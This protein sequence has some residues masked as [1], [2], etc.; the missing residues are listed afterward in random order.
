MTISSVLGS[1][2]G[3]VWLG[4]ALGA[5][6]T[7]FKSSECYQRIRGKKSDQALQV[8]ESAV[9]ET[10]RTYVQAIKAARADGRLSGEEKKQARQLAKERAFALAKQQGL[11]LLRLLGNDNIDLWLTKSVNR[12]KSS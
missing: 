3:I 4:T 5:I 10:Y 1:E 12:L 9:E 6:W 7:L 8:L 11:D 2:Q